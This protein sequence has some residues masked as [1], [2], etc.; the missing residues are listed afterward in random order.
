MLLVDSSSVLCKITRE[1]RDLGQN[2]GLNGK[3][4]SNYNKQFKESTLLS[5]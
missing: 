5:F 2:S 3:H 1:S 4:V